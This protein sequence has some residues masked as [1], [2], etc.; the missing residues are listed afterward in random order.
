MPRTGVNGPG[1]QFGQWFGQFKR[2]KGFQSAKKTL[3]SFRH[4]VASELRLA[5]ATDPQ[6]DAIT[7]HAGQG[8]GRTVYSATI[9]RE[10][11]RLRP[12]IELLA[13][14]ELQSLRALGADGIAPL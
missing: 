3:H 7:G 6:A 14:P 12:V 13:F 4:L 9:R 5:G 10:A 8:L 1:G 11:A 2:A